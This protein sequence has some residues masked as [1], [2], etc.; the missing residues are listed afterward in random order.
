MAT[1]FPSS[2]D[3]FTNPTSSDTLDSPDHAAQHTNVNDAV[4]AIELALL[5]GAPM[6]IDD[7]NERVGIGTTSPSN[8]LHVNGD[9]YFVNDLR[10]GDDLVV[11][12]NMT[13]G[14]TGQTTATLHAIYGGNVGIGTTSPSAKLEVAHGTNAELR[15]NDTGGT[16]GGSL[17][18]KVALK[19][20]GS[21]AGVLGFNN[22]GSGILTL[23]NE[24]GAVY[25]QTKTSDNILLRTNSTT[26]LTI[27]DSTRGGV[28]YTPS[29]SY[30]SGGTW[31][32]EYVLID[33]FLMVTGEWTFT[34]GASVSNFWRIGLPSG[35]T[36]D[37]DVVGNLIMTDFMYGG[38]HIG[39]SAGFA[40][41]SDIF[42]YRG[43]E[44]GSKLKGSSVTSTSPF[45]WGT[46]DAFKITISGTVS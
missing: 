7:S 27:S 32:F 28:A 8:K 16:V 2:Q 19:G 37:T 31:D 40:G 4:E 17:N 1:N 6:Y 10:V 25:L 46:S 35:L 24:D 14:Q 45:T 9:G 29:T 44:S 21:D 42:A 18:A 22:T 43:V 39:F 3:S 12:D 26:R 13:V 30:I 41:G 33:K 20:N 23:T 11:N 34:S 15:L 5:D 38:D 36:W